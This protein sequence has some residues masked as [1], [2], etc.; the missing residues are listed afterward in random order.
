M[1]DDESDICADEGM[2]SG[3]EPDLIGEIEKITVN[4]QVIYQVLL[5]TDCLNWSDLYQGEDDADVC[6]F[7]ASFNEKLVNETGESVFAECNKEIIKALPF[8]FIKAKERFEQSLSNSS[9]DNGNV[10]E[11]EFVPFQREN[12]EVKKECV[13]LYGPRPYSFH[14]SKLLTANRETNNNNNAVSEF[15]SRRLSPAVGYIGL[16]RDDPPIEDSGATTVAEL[17][18][19]NA[20]L[21][22]VSKLIQALESDNITK[23]RVAWLTFESI[24]S[25]LTTI[26]T[27][28][29]Q[30]KHI[31]DLI[32]YTISHFGGVAK[33]QGQISAVI[34]RDFLIHIRA[35]GHTVPLAARA[36]IS[37]WAETLQMDW[38]YSDNLV[39]SAMI[40]R[41]GRKVA[42]APPFKLKFLLLLEELIENEDTKI[43]LKLFAAAI[44]LTVHASL[45]F[46]DIQ[47]MATFNET[48]EVIHGTLTACKVKKQHGLPWPFAALRKGFNNKGN[49]H[50][51][52]LDFRQA[53][54]ST[55]RVFPT[56]TIP[57]INDEWVIQSFEPANY[58]NA[59]RKLL[60]LAI[61]MKEENPEKYTLHSGKNFYPTC[62]AQMR[63]EREKRNKLGHWSSFSSMAERYDRSTC[64]TE[65]QLRSDI[66][67]AITCGWAPVESFQIP[68]PVPVVNNEVEKIETDSQNIIDHQI[69]T[70]TTQITKNKKVAKRI[71]LVEKT[72][73]L[74]CINIERGKKVTEC[75]PKKLPVVSRRI[76]LA[77]IK[78]K[79]GRPKKNLR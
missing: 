27:I 33:L 1:M 28:R 16:D 72:T 10:I 74:E 37:T 53:Y 54:Y 66:L 79:V 52:I 64:S 11:R 15:R 26:N 68:V 56:F 31:S 23:G 7:I 49:W 39:R 5:D 2:V 63:M 65:L 62:G 48:N 18:A 24:H 43:G 13:E 8:L 44:L 25:R 71:V 14:N 40:D 32:G 12:S 76:Q 42:Q 3:I 41:E 60:M 4:P 70:T 51:P 75:S 6:T 77:T 45:R 78:R 47:R 36:A 59:R 9:C 34:I 19:I 69:S 58:N 57:L 67:S 21:R 61:E 22:P 46:S 35:R 30:M 17:W 55:Q 38:R 20:Q 29:R 73:T 50:R